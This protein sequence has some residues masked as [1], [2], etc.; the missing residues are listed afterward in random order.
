MYIAILITW[1]IFVVGGY[2][3]GLYHHIDM[4][5][6]LFIALVVIGGVFMLT[7]GFE[8]PS[9]GYNKSSLPEVSIERGKQKMR[10][11]REN[12]F[13]S[14]PISTL[15]AYMCIPLIACLIF[16]ILI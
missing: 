16:N 6:N 5:F 1:T 2:I 8:I 15:L 3:Y 13:H 12:Q 14:T 4:T 10:E 11:K 7:E 9:I